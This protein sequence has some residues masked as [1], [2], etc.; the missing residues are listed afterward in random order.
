MKAY[1]YLSSQVYFVDRSVIMGSTPLRVTWIEV[2]LRASVLEMLL[3]VTLF[4]VT[5]STTSC[6][7]NQ[8]KL[9]GLDS[10]PAAPSFVSVS[11]H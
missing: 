3:T 4:S 8:G 1:V 2:T 6:Q 9:A 10:N 7:L 5:R 11:F